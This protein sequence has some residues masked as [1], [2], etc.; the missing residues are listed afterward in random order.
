MIAETV[1]VRLILYGLIAFAPE[2][3]DQANKL[4]AL[5]VDATGPQYSSDGCAIPRHVP[6]LYA[7][8]K[9]CLDNGLPCS[10]SPGVEP[11]VDPISGSWPLDGQILKIEVFPSENRSARQLVAVRNASIRSRAELPTS[12]TE[13]ESLSWLPSVEGLTVDP[14]CLVDASHCP[15]ISRVSFDNGR[16]T[17]CH[18]AQ[19]KE[20]NVFPYE[21]KPLG[22]DTALPA[23][24][25]MS[26]AVMVSL[27]I[28]KSAWVRIAFSPLHPEGCSGL[29]QSRSIVLESGTEEFIDVWIANVPPYHDSGSDFQ[30]CHDMA[31]SID[32]HWELFY[33]LANRR[34]PFSQRSV[35]HRRTSG[36][37]QLA[38]VVQPKNCPLLKFDQSRVAGDRAVLGQ[39]HGGPPRIP[40]DWKSCVGYWFSTSTSQP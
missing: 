13:S 16:V 37:R 19:T 11:P 14:D 39:H 40:N 12:P 31:S 17:S 26:D 22:G 33:N 8:A 35:P 10:S 18:L 5:L 7:R 20:N 34:V 25:A 21:L 32:R 9:R 38:D 30:E 15:I 2:S 36:E 24:Q 23:Q 28:P 3:G 29:G 27:E 6:V 1:T 4:H